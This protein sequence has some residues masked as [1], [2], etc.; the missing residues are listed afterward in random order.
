M[1][2]RIVRGQFAGKF[3]TFWDAMVNKKTNGA[4]I[5]IKTASPDDE[6]M[7]LIKEL[8]PMIN[9]HLLNT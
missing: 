2:G 7:P 9:K 8:V 1:N 4:V 5:V 3:F 6:I